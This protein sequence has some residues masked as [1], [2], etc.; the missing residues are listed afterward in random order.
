[1]EVATIKVVV[2]LSAH[3]GLL[4]AETQQ[5]PSQAARR[6]TGRPRSDEQ[7]VVRGLTVPPCWMRRRSG[8]ELPVS[9][10]AA[11]IIIIVHCTCC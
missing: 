9:R 2:V 4:S 1:M 11:G 10:R 5:Q 3:L 7:M 8:E 6:R